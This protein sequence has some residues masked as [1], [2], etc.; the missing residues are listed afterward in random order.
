MYARAR[1][2]GLAYIYIHPLKLITHARA[3]NRRERAA[4]A[5]LFVC[6]KYWHKVTVSDDAREVMMSAC[7]G[8]CAGNCACRG[9]MIFEYG[10]WKFLGYIE[11]F[12]GK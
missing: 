11:I 4:A 2:L 6:G 10:V 8:A 3:A 1:A 12:N 5:E 7:A 9:R